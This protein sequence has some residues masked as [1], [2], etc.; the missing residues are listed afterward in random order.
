MMW[1]P[2][3]VSTAA[4]HTTPVLIRSSTAAP[5]LPGRV[6]GQSPAAEF[7]PLFLRGSAIRYPQEF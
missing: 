7:V 1:L 5:E 3:L 4:L 6:Y 2:D